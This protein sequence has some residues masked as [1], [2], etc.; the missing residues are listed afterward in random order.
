LQSVLAGNTNA[1][2]F[3]IGSNSAPATAL[4]PSLLQYALQAVGSTS[5]AQ[6]VL[7][8]NMGNSPLL[9]SSITTS[10]NFAEGDD[11]GS[12]V[13]AAGSCAF[14][15]TFVPVAAG[16]LSGSIV[17]QDDSAGS[18]HLIDLSGDSFGPVVSLAPRSLT[19]SGQ[20]VGTTGAEQIVTLTNTGNTVLSVSGA[21][22]TGD[23][24]QTN[25]CSAPL[26]A[27]SSCAIN[28]TF[29]PTASGTRIGTLTVSDSAANSP[30][31]DN[32]TGSGSDFILASSSGSDTIKA[33]SAASYDLMVSPVGG[34]FANAVALSCS[35]LPAQTSCSLSP[36]VVTPGG[37]TVTS[38]LSI[39]TTASVAEVPPIRKSRSAPVYAVWVQLQSIGLLGI[40]FAMPKRLSKK[41]RALVLLS[42]VSGA[43]VFMIGCGGTG[44][45]P[46]PHAGTTPGTYA[47]TVTGTSGHMQHSLSLTLVVD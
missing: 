27:G 30:Q 47:I 26:G 32:L 15:V 5:P 19:F 33:G 18:P 4:S 21:Q 9:I 29:T 22:V 2:V 3:K 1:F 41:A 45:V 24:A 28:I 35:G 8:R 25:N 10:V 36:N 11:C 46:T 16:S 7:L 12:S 43:L 39:T 44:I 42:L 6:T 37:S 20:Q 40:M 31:T 17:I 13:P 14:S 34:S 38:M 23:F